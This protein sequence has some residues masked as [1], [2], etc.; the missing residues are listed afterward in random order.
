[1]RRLY[2]NSDRL[3]IMKRFPTKT[4]RCIGQYAAN[5]HIGR[6]TNRNSSGIHDP[7]LS[8]ADWE[9]IQKYGW[10]R[11]R[12]AHWLPGEPLGKNGDLSK[13]S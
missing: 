13:P 11:E 12:A 3:D 10:T 2:P 4:W 1:M 6:N 7:I 8:L 5:R 9:L